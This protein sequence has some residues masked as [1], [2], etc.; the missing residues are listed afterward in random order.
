[1]DTRAV[2]SVESGSDGL[3]LVRSI[4]EDQPS[5]MRRALNGSE[6]QAAILLAMR[7]LLI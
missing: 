6:L 3:F 1:M 7:Q 2:V 5:C 4:K